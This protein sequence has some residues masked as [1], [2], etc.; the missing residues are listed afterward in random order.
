MNTWR[1]GEVLSWREVDFGWEVRNGTEESVEIAHMDVKASAGGP[2]S[3]YVDGVEARY[4]LPFVLEPRDTV[5]VSR[6]APHMSGTLQVQRSQK[7]LHRLS[8]VQVGLQD[9]KYH[10]LARLT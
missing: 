5:E 6:K 1:K 4:A 9:A 3:V 7:A 10:P 2:R 8:R